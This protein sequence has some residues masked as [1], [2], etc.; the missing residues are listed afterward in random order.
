MKRQPLKKQDPLLPPLPVPPANLLQL[1]PPLL[2]PPP[3]AARRDKS[4]SPLDELPLVFLWALQQLLHPSRRASKSSNRADAAVAAATAYLADR[5][6]LLPVQLEIHERGVP[7]ELCHI[8]A[9]TAGDFKLFFEEPL[10][11]TQRRGCLRR[12]LEAASH[13][14]KARRKTVST[15]ER[16]ELL[17]G[18]L[19]PKT[20]SFDACRPLVG[21]VTAG[22]ASAGRVVLCQPPPS[23]KQCNNNFRP[24]WRVRLHA[25][26]AP[27][28]SP[29]GFSWAQESVAVGA[30]C[31]RRSCESPHPVLHE[32]SKR[33]DLQTRL[34]CSL[35]AMH[36]LGDLRARMNLLETRRDYDTTAAPVQSQTCNNSSSLLLLSGLSS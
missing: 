35:C 29:K 30:L 13:K 27:K 8:Y 4:W 20:S 33:N 5:G 21:F 1:L 14:G 36:S 10:H 23:C 19:S 32:E 15:A 26:K 11:R 18:A 22:E 12:K 24:L 25:L 34:L 17:E 16:S 28:I 31:M 2:V 6:A 3:A 9:L 7:L